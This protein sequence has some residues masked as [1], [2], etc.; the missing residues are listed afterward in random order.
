MPKKFQ[1]IPRI[2]WIPL[3]LTLTL[4]SVTYFGSRLFTRERY[5][6]NLSGGLDDYIP[7]VPWTVVIYLGC[8]IFWVINYIIGCRQER[9]E[10]FRFISADFAAKLVC[11]LCYM[12]FPTTN[13][14]PVIT[15]NSLWE[16]L[17]GLLYQMDAAD[18][19][20]PSIHCL[21][22]WFCFLAVRKNEKIPLWYKWLSLFIAVSIC[23]STLTTKQHVLIDVFAGVAL[24][25][26]SYLFV[27]KSGFSRWYGNLMAKGEK[28]M[29][30][31]RGW[32]HGEKY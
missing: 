19:L 20:L 13:T 24:A 29:S 9:N 6:F 26:L 31:R 16:E 8:Y 30:D 27:E 17:M 2:M 11:L 4:N 23:I 5:H 28:W 15:G 18:N 14:R 1:I 22:S 32:V 25:E 12:I 21:T 3:I 7:F 10:A